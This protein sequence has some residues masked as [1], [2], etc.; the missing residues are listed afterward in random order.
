MMGVMVNARHATG[1]FLTR[2]ALCGLLL[3]M[4]AGPL[5]ALST[6]SEQAINIEADQAELDDRRQVAVYTGSVVITQGTLRIDADKVE[7]Y[8]DDEKGLTRAIALGEPARYRQLPDDS[9]E[10]TQAW[11]RKMEFLPLK[12]LVHL[13]EEAKWTQGKDSVTG[14]RIT[15][16]TLRDK[17]KAQ[18][19][20]ES[21]GRVR[22]TI[23]PKK[24]SPESPEP[25][26]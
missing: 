3:G 15:Y 22:V 25:T 18:T 5:M 12:S 14:D 23:Q 21:K 13:I 10:Y 16:D 19:T 17:A 20:R 7:M 2:Q 26:P 1:L 11:A 8:Y 9:E 4:L 6:D 24:K